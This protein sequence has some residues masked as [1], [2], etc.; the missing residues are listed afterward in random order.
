[1]SDTQNSE[2]IE[3]DGSNPSGPNVGDHDVVVMTRCGFEHQP[4]TVEWWAGSGKPEHSNWHQTGE[5]HDI[6]AYRVVK[7]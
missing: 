4:M 7:P 1:M 2:W 5:T 6:V 3:W